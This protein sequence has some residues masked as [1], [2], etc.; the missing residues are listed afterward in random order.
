MTDTQEVV[1]SIR[2]CDFSLYFDSFQEVDIMVLCIINIYGNIYPLIIFT[3]D[4]AILTMMVVGIYY[5]RYYFD[6]GGGREWGGE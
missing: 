4:T 1:K 6:L 5:F 3:I 2:F